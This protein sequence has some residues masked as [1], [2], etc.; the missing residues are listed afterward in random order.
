MVNPVLLTCHPVHAAVADRSMWA[1][2]VYYGWDDWLAH[3]VMASMRPIVSWAYQEMARQ[4]TSVI[5]VSQPIL[6][7]IGSAR[8]TVVPNGMTA[9][10]YDD[11]P[12]PPEWFTSLG[13]PV[14]FYAG[15]LEHRVD[16]E[17]I[18]DAA[19]KLENWTF[20]LVGPM[21]DPHRFSALAG[22]PNVT[23]HPPVAHQE[24]LAMARA[25]TVGIIPH[26]RTE[27]SVSMNP[28][29]LYEYLGAGIPVVAADLPPIRGVSERVLLVE[30]GSTYA[31]AIEA[32]ATMPPLPNDELVAWR[33]SNS[34]EDRYQ[35]FK[36]AALEVS[37]A[38]TP[39]GWESAVNMANP[40]LSQRGS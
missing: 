32:A 4:N 39:L 14:A 19:I 9:A 35:R 13:G 22:Q 23:I 25:S 37:T 6:D 40:R 34:W 3:P 1:D 7:R 5:A 2:V 11:L 36:A 28:L 18:L 26:R 12:E 16:V 21:T 20:C 29:K 31:P 33:A 10:D 38:A 15:A 24:I 30:P 8:S 17:G 27:M